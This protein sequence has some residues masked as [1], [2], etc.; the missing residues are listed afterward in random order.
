M[1]ADGAGIS[2]ISKVMIDLDQADAEAAL[3]RRRQFNV[4]LACGDDVASSYT[5]QLAVLTA[6][7]IGS[8]CFP[9]A[10]RTAI[11]PKLAHAPLLLWPWRKITFGEAVLE[12]LGVAAPDAGDGAAPRHAL[13]FGEAPENKNALRVTFDG[14]TAKVGP[15]G[16]VPR[17]P[18][19]EYFSGAGILASSLALSELFLSFAE[20]SIEATRRVVGLSLWRPDLYIGDARALGPEVEFLPRHL[21]V[22]GLDHLGNAYLWSLAT[23]PYRDPDPVELALFDFDKVEKENV[24]T[25]IIL[26]T[27]FL[28]RFKTRACDAWLEQCGFRTRLVE[29]HF[30]ATFRRQEDEPALA[31]CG[32]D[33]ESGAPGSSGRPIP[34]HHR[35]RPRRPGEQLRHHQL[36]HLAECASGGGTMA[37]PGRQGKGEACRASRARGART[38]RLRTARS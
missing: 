28:N 7:S 11:S 9:G 38:F 12:I 3:A 31:L 23:L 4:T 19:R 17:L 33:F 2:R 18:E 26:S 27:Q 15:A 36:S 24:E 37:G 32:F 21:W 1:S 14:W 6:A 29:R 5:L 25:G 13:V 35:R 30:D 16:V 22:L 34:P 10:V 8:R 20:I